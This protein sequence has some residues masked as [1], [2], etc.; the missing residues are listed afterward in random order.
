MKIYCVLFKVLSTFFINVFLALT[1]AVMLQSK[2]KKKASLWYLKH[3][4]RR[5][6][7]PRFRKKVASQKLFLSE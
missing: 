4:I 6:Q 7:I 2:E 1:V 3:V 5:T